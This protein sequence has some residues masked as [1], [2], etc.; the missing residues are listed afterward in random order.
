MKHLSL[1]LCLAIGLLVLAQAR[2]CHAPAAPA[3]SLLV[4]HAWV[5]VSWAEKTGSQAAHERILPCMQDDIIRFEQVNGRN[6]YTE[7]PGTLRCGPPE[8]R[9]SQAEWE[10]SE[11]S[12]ALT[13]RGGN[14]TF[15]NSWE[16]SELTAASLKL[17]YRTNTSAG[18]FVMTLAF[19]KR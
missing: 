1:L 14:S 7:T 10:L 17:T 12:R 18:P 11:D 13:I 3:A 2:T 16:V 5:W 4:S 19:A 15:V 9:N 6:V 8:R